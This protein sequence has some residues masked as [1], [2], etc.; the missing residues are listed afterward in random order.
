[1]FLGVKIGGLLK[2]YFSVQEAAQQLHSLHSQLGNRL[3]LCYEKYLLYHHLSLTLPKIYR[4][5]SSQLILDIITF[6][7]VIHPSVTKIITMRD[8]VLILSIFLTFNFYCDLSNP[9]K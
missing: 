4:H 9:V 7:L 2:D 5:R 8:E 3:L 1:M 6:I